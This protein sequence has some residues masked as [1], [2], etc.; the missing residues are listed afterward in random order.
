MVTVGTENWCGVVSGWWRVG[1]TVS[2]HNRTLALDTHL[3]KK[4][5]K[6]KN[7]KRERDHRT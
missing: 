5:G 7:K 1:D 6:K 2:G 4:R 3:E